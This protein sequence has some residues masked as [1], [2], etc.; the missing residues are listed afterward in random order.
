MTISCTSIHTALQYLMAGDDPIFQLPSCVCFA[1]CWT[2]C[3]TGNSCLFFRVEMKTRTGLEIPL[4]RSAFTRGLNTACKKTPQAPVYTVACNTP[5]PVPP[6]Y[7]GAC[8]KTPPVPVFYTVACNTYSGACLHG[9]LQ[10]TPH[11]GVCLHGC[12]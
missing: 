2:V 4:C 9:C 1:E 10:Y 3:F 8:K 12:L 6:V 11:P 7:T 5:P